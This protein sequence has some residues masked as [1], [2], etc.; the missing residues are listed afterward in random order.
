VI[1]G[2]LLAAGFGRR[3]GGN[4]LVRPLANGV[5]VVL[6]AATNLASAVDQVLVVVRPG[7]AAV[8][9]V[10]E[11]AGLGSVVRCARAELGMGHSI[12]CGVQASYAAQGWVIA[13]GDMPF[14]RET[15]VRQVADRLRGGALVAAPVRGSRRG[16]PVG[17]GSGL[18]RAL[19]QLSG[20]SGARALIQEH[21]AAAEL[22]EVD[23]PGIF[24]DID[25]AAD[26]QSSDN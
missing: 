17:F 2:I 25:R 10:I 21:I 11:N 20:R 14:L 24:A 12:A 5:P 7:D 8:A 23:D 4:K 6:R 26:L 13:L 3:F 22:F 19:S 16:H 18:R 1:Q 15:T 9:P